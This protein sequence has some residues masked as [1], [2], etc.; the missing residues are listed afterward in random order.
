MRVCNRGT[1]MIAD[2]GEMG[3]ARI[4]GETVKAQK[5]GIINGRESPT[6]VKKFNHTSQSTCTSSTGSQGHS[7]RNHLQLHC[8][9]LLQVVICCSTS[10][11]VEQCGKLHELRPPFACSACNGIVQTRR[12]RYTTCISREMTIPILTFSRCW[13]LCACNNKTSCC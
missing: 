8:R 12:H 11:I 4:S 6:Q 7:S 9:P 5:K 3:K 1:K 10:F 2:Q 13:H